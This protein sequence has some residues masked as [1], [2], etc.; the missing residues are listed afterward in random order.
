MLT[1][2]SP[3]KL[4]TNLRAES[5]RRPPPSTD[6]LELAKPFRALPLPRA[7]TRVVDDANSTPYH[8]RAQQQYEMARERKE[9][10]IEE[11]MEAYTA[12]HHQQR[13][14][15]VPNT[16][17]VAQPIEKPTQS[18]PTLT[19]PKPPRLS[20]VGRAEERKLFDQQAEE[21]RSADIATKQMREQQQKELE[22]EETRKQRSSYA[23]E[24]G[25]CF[26]AKEISITYQ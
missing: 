14:R 18:P 24:G 22:E 26:K 8:I 9:R 7:S 21:L 2:P 11:E 23:E 4:R 20:L 12:A 25:C 19:Q 6:A 3:F 5:T 13:A 17:Y 15:K 16:T 1:T 10:L